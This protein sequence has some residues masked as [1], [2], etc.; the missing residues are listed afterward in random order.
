M[1][2]LFGVEIQGN[3]PANELREDEDLRRAHEIEPRVD[4]RGIQRAVNDP[5]ERE[6]G[7]AGW[8]IAL[9]LDDWH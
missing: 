5:A 2:D 4:D 7:D 6:V 8:H 3:R 1:H 9:L